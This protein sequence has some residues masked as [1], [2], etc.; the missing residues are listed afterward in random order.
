MDKTKPSQKRIV[1]CP[2]P[3]WA[4]G[5]NKLE[6][7]ETDLRVNYS[8]QETAQLVALRDKGTLTDLARRV[9]DQILNERGVSVGELECIST[10]V[11]MQRNEEERAIYAPSQDPIIR[12]TSMMTGFVKRRKNPS[13]SFDA[14][15]NVVISSKVT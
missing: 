3:K 5:G 6:I 12:N 14:T 4:S 13:G 2:D 11:R 9:L 7:T 10:A 1:R 15:A 8:A